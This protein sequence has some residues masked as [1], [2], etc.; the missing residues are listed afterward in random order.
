M[1]ILV[2]GKGSSGSWK[3]RGEQLGGAIGAQVVARASEKQIKKAD[4]VIVVKKPWPG[5]NKA[6]LTV[7]DM[8]D[9]YPQPASFSWDKQ[10]LINWSKQHIAPYNKTVA[11]TEK[12]QQ[13]LQTDFWL[14]HHFRP[15]IEENQIRQQ[16]QVVGYEGCERYLGKYLPIIAEQCKKRG[17]QFVIN[18]ACLA[19]CDVLLAVRD[20]D[21]RGYASDNWKSC[22]KM[23]NAI[24]SLTPLI[25]LPES[26]YVETHAPFISIDNTSNIS[27]AF[28]VVSDFETRFHIAN[29]YLKLK[30]LYEL[31]TVAQEYLQWLTSLY[32]ST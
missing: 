24:G 18:P 6:K 14:R 9:C 8:V 19:Q 29:Q 32:Q 31:N 21:W 27:D 13:D 16:V 3:V 12:M 23:S 30:P 25:A 5:T 7:Y 15:N 1:K 17:W 28:D 22:V 11:A 20:D 26:G 2:T 4:I 10:T